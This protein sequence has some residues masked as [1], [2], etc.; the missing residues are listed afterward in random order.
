LPKTGKKN[1]QV[2]QVGTG[3]DGIILEKGQLL[4]EGG[5]STT[6]R[7]GEARKGR[8]VATLTKR[9]G[10]VDFQQTKKR[11]GNGKQKRGKEPPNKTRRGLSAGRKTMKDRAP[12]EGE[13]GK[14]QHGKKEL[15][16]CS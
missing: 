13:K 14:S 5:P 11:G 15:R 12:L 16:E 1:T 8:F 6:A 3:K 4:S 7:G 2:A 9:K 10:T